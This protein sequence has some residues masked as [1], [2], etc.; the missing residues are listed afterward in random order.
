MPTE[1]AIEASEELAR[2]WPVARWQFTLSATLA[3]TEAFRVARFRT[4]RPKILMFA[5]KYHGHADEMLTT[6]DDQGHTTPEYLGIQPSAT[7][8]VTIVPFNDVDALDRALTG[9][10]VAAVVT[11][12]ALTN[13]GIVL[14]DPGFHDALRDLTR[15]HGTLLILDETHTLI[16]GRGG[17]T[18]AWGLEPD[19]VTVG[20]SI[21]AGI[22]VGAYGMTEDVADALESHVADGEDEYARGLDSIFGEEVATGGTL[23]GN[24]LQM[25]AVRTTLAEVLTDDAY[26]HTS[27]LG[28]KLADG[29]DRIASHAGL[30]WTAERLGPRSGYAFTGRLARDAEEAHAFHDAELYRLLRLY[31]LNRGVWEAME[32]A[33]PAISVPASDADVDHYLEVLASLVAELT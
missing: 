18:R 12:P 6:T 30:P 1:D 22:P 32:W 28:E 21:G 20:K 25:T 14:P 13:V 27:R 33:G 5:G 16:T 19:V 26:D 4:G 10:D 9:R 7:Q 23:F 2:R 3:N 17:L 29:I 8:N 11:E 31:L 24:A 15:S